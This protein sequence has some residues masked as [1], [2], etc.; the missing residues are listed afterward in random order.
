[1]FLWLALA[2]GFTLGCAASLAQP[3]D[4]DATWARQ[5]WPE[6]TVAE[7]REGRSIFVSTCSGCH[8]LPDPA[9]HSP[10]EW[11]AI[12]DEMRGEQEVELS[13]D[14]RDRLVWYLSAISARSTR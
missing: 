13:V 1:M 12:V 5:R 2:T 4:R 9:T 7:L 6:A 10:K 3:T 14:E 8:E 11:P